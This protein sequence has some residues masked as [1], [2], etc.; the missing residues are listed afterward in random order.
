MPVALFLYKLTYFFRYFSTKSGLPSIS[1]NAKHAGDM[2]MIFPG[3]ETIVRFSHHCE[4]DQLEKSFCNLR[5]RVI[6]HSFC[7]LLHPM[8]LSNKMSI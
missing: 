8:L 6:T 3:M 4:K 7:D 5:L 2:V 1:S